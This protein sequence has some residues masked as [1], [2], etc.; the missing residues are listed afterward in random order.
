MANPLPFQ[1]PGMEA[2]R[3]RLQ[4][5]LE[6]V[7]GGGG[8]P[9]DGGMDERVKKLENLAE[10]T[11]DRLTVIERDVAVMK[12]N[13]ATKEDM[14]SLA[15]ELHKELHATTWKIIG[16]VALLCAAV[17]W[18]ARNVAPPVSSATASSVTQPAAAQSPIA[19]PH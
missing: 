10:K 2:E 6:A 17:F 19:K 14:R 1:L 12:S 11:V 15:V 16:T 7:D 13:Y 5:L 9:H 3:D 18:M 8:P 4:R